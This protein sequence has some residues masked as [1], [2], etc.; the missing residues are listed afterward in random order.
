MRGSDGVFGAKE[1]LTK[2][3]AITILIRSLQGAQEENVTP[4]W[5][6]YFLA[7]QEVK[8]TKEADVYALDRPLTRYELSLLLWRVQNPLEETSSTSEK[9][10]A[11]VYTLLQELGLQQD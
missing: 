8:L 11:D 3:Q 1:Y 10:L 2:A 9:D 7:A 4:W 5:K 6:N